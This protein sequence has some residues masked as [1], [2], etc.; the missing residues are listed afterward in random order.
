MSG[1][2]AVL[3]EDERKG[4][5]VIQIAIRAEELKTCEVCGGTFEVHSEDSLN[6]AYRIGNAL[7]SNNDP[8]TRDFKNTSQRRRELT[9]MLQNLW[10][11]F[12]DECRCKRQAR[13]D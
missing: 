6:T 7:I 10:T 5:A 3:A 4:G 13:E 8:L 12:S 9:D 11:D 1:V 2:K